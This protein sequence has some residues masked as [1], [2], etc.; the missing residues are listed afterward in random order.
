[1]DQT[2]KDK[3]TLRAVLVGVYLFSVPAFA[4][5]EELGLLAIPQV[6]GALL[7]AYA[8]LDILRSRLK[9]PPEIQLYGLLGLWAAMTFV[10]AAHTGEIPTMR[11][12]SLVKVVVAT[13]ACAQLIKDET[14]LFTALKIFVFSILLVY[15]LNRESLQI[16]RVADQISEND[17]FGG[18]FT[19]P[20]FAAMFSLAI[21]WASVVLFLHARRGWLVGGLYLVPI[22]IALLVIYYTGSKKGLIGVAVFVLFLTRILYMRQ[23]SSLGGKSLILLISLSLIILSGYF[24]LTS[25]FYFRMQ[26]LFYGESAGDIKRLEL[27]RESIGVW[28]M[29]WKTFFMGVGYENFSLFSRY[30]TVAHATP[31]ELLASNGIVGCSLFLGFLILLFRKFIFLYR[32]ALNQKS[33]SIFFSVLIFLF[34][35][36]FFMLTDVLSDSREMLP[37]LGCLGAFGQYHLLRLRQTQTDEASAPD[38]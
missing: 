4:Y 18:T 16:L 24:I 23:Q 17:R 19:S 12:G 27:A 37:I 20:N 6:T 2:S 9:I 28:L 30:Q 5:S 7:V 34:L 11:L 36:T 1:V 13:L 26:E 3:I 33:K 21:I 15:Y 38:R 29:N 35:Y 25:P 14:D 22:G 31:L 10:F 8:I 32:H